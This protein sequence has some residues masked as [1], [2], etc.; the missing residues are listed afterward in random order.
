MHVM[1]LHAS[2][3]NFSRSYK[4][5]VYTVPAHIPANMHPS[6]R[7]RVKQNLHL[8]DT[9]TI[10]NGVKQGGVIAYILFVN[11]IDEML[12]RLKHSGVSSHLCHVYC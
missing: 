8:N 5:R 1:L 10:T 9:F 6:Q 2:M 7:I 3:L 4:P 12:K 11:C